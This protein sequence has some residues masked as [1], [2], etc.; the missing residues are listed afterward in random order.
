VR[1]KLIRLVLLL[2]ANALGLLIASIVFEGVDVDFTSFLVVV[3]VFTVVLAVA[4]P[5]VRNLTED[6]APALTGGVAIITTLLSLIVTNLLLSGLSID[7]IGTWFGATVVVWVCAALAAV[8]LPK[9][10]LEKRLS[11]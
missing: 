4:A 11:A 2:A 6:K 8:V 9:V 1:S 7:G 5:L 3:V 10:F